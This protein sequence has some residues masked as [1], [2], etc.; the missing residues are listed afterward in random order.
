MSDFEFI[1]DVGSELE[2][3]P[4]LLLAKL[5]SI[6]R[7]VPDTLI[8]DAEDIA[9][10]FVKRSKEMNDRDNH[11]HLENVLDVLGDTALSSGVLSKRVKDI[12]RVR[13]QEIVDEM[14]CK[15]RQGRIMLADASED[16]PKVLQEC[17]DLRLQAE[18]DGRADDMVLPLPRFVNMQRVRLTRGKYA[19]DLALV[20]YP[21]IN[22][23][24][25][26]PQ[27]RS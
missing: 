9:S 26:P 16:I 7:V 12:R 11:E 27:T 4:H 25:W 5:D 19:D 17:N 21:I 23:K 3:F 24:R 18:L 15:R 14:N 22:G 6:S 20:F 8:D 10:D 2:T 13:M 1:D